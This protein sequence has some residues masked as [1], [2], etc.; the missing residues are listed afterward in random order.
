MVNL[1]NLSAGLALPELQNRSLN[2]VAELAIRRHES[3]TGSEVAFGYEGNADCVGDA[4]RVCTYRVVQEGLANAYHHGEARGQ[5]VAISV[6]DRITI[7]VS[8]RGPGLKLA[9]A[10]EDG[11]V[12][13]GLL[14]LRNRVTAL[15]GSLEFG[16]RPGGGAELKVMLPLFD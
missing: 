13:L 3:L 16:G 15:K 6:S 14:G 8:D 7:L 5:S 10:A 1:R 4:A 12:R 2:E 9:E 11:R